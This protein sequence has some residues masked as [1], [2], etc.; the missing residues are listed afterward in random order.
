MFDN[1]E[2]PVE[3]KEDPI[4]EMAPANPCQG[5]DACLGLD[6]GGYNSRNEI[7]VGSS[8]AGS[9]P[10]A[11]LTTYVDYGSTSTST[12]FYGYM[13]GFSSSGLLDDDDVYTLVVPWGYGI[14]VTVSWNSTYT[15]MY[16][17]IGSSGM[18][19]AS[20]YQSSGATVY[21]YSG[22]GASGSFTLS[23]IGNSVSDTVV[24]IYLDC[25]SNYCKSSMGYTSDYTM[26]I[27]TWPSDAGNYGDE[28]EQFSTGMSTWDDGRTYVGMCGQYGGSFCQVGPGTNNGADSGT[29]T[30]ALG[31]EFG[32]FINYDNYADTESTL[33]VTCTS[34]AGY[35]I[36]RYNGFIP[37]S[38]GAGLF[39]TT[40]TGPDTCTAVTTDIYND[41]GIEAYWAGLSPAVSG[42]LSTTTSF[43]TISTYGVVGSSDTYDVYAAVIPDDAFAN[44]TLE[45]NANADLDLRVYADS[46]LTTL[47]GSSAGSSNPEVVDMG[48][49]TDTTVYVKVS[50]YAPASADPAAGYKIT[51]NLL[52]TVFPPCW[53]QDDGAAPGTGVYD[54]TG[55]DAADDSSLGP[56]DVSGTTSFTG[57]L[58]EDNDEEDWYT[59]SIPAYHGA[60]V[61]LTWDQTEFTDDLRL[62][63]YA[64][65]PGYSYPTTISSASSTAMDGAAVATTNESYAWTTSVRILGDANRSHDQCRCVQPRRRSRVQLHSR[66]RSLQYV[67][68]LLGRAME[69]RRFRHRRWKQLQLHHEPPTASINEQHLHGIRTR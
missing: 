45:W 68:R 67:R 18:S 10:V 46:S 12:T 7:C 1:A 17:A 34:G 15:M 3:L 16:G 8:T 41:G 57:M 5:Y 23:T 48:S 66:I 53:F 65:R 29:K 30:I 31:E 52:P 25:Y 24:D 64:Q 2:E 11:N 6:A 22:Y 59:V 4:M 26:T 19:A 47:I 20:T 40:F 50:F 32:L 42:M 56:M 49:T 35:S 63:L 44:V 37:N 36:A 21:G 9:C 58:C 54:G 38:D 60:Y 61:K 33:T 14:N 51:L 13:D 28:T 39:T 55:S 27:E 62:Y 69:R 43:P